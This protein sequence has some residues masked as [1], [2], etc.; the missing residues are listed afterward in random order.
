MPNPNRSGKDRV[1]H[2][3][4]HI[5]P[6][7]LGGVG[8]STH[9]LS[10]ALSDRFEVTVASSW[11]GES[12]PPTG[13]RYRLATFAAKKSF[14]GNPVSP[15]MLGWLLK[16]GDL[17]DLIHVHSHLFIN[18]DLAAIIAKVH[19]KPVVLSNHGF[20]SRSYPLL[21]Q[22]AWIRIVMKTI[23]SKCDRLLCYSRFDAEQF[24][25]FGAPPE[26][27]VIVPNA[28]DTERFREMP[29]DFSGPLR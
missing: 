17:F 25:K 15:R 4:A 21:A 29:R 9:E 26:R 24:I 6:D 23:F 14:F 2:V 3:T 18:S 22:K 7:V 16:N 19:S 28:V 11:V 10:S 1:L 13:L 12:R 20:V 8:M 5:Y 27:V